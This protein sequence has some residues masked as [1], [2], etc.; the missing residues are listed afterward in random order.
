[1]KDPRIEKLA[2][3]LV[4]YSCEVKPGDRV[5]VECKGTQTIPLAAEC[6]RQATII[7]GIPFWYY[8]GEDLCRPFLQSA[9]DEQ[10]QIHGQLH[11]GI[12]EQMDCYIGI[13]GS[14]NPF[15]L[16][17]MSD[18]SL[19]SMNKHIW[20]AVHIEVRLSKRWVVLRYPTPSMSLQ[21]ELPTEK[22]ED[23]YFQVCTL[24]YANMNEAM[25][26]LKA[27]MERTDK[28][29]I[30]GKDTDLR[31]SIKGMAAVPCSGR[32]NIPDGEIF[33]APIIDS[34]NGT[35]YYNAPSL[36][37]STRFAGVRFR[38]EKGR[39]VEASCDGDNQKLNAILDTDEGA[40]YIGEFALGINPYI[41][42]PMLDTLFDEKINGS[43]HLTPGN[44]YDETDNG[45]KSAIHWDLVS[46]QLPNWGGGEIYFDDVLIR[47]DG[48][49]VHPE[50]K[51]V[52]S[53]EA[54][55]R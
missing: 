18:V 26:P 49:F 35:I 36:Y 34:I 30:I 21:A 1:M 4:N 24:D 48:V 3:N 6:C 7:G 25:K 13:R 54:L 2:S 41:N 8:N 11:R 12:M 46:I 37:H 33:T 5:M 22:F 50:L 32:L 27:L 10:F 14:D 40:R 28:V 23:F 29:R 43:F 17:D 38:F 20:Q 9:N 42:K 45:N 55:K 39:I 53:E 16:A 52:L 51:D 31:F 15:D 47:K 19:K 44:A